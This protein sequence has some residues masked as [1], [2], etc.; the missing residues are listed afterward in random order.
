ML[1]D[2]RSF[3][4]RDRIFTRRPVALV[5]PGAYR[6]SRR[7]D[8]QREALPMV[9]VCPCSRAPRGARRTSFATV[10]LTK[11]EGACPRPPQLPS[12]S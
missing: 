9:H 11:G 4:G 7:P 12:N 5:L 10:L 8:S 2:T 1:S 6:E 3:Y